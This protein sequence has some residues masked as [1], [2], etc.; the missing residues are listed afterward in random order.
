MT[1]YNLKHQAKSKYAYAYDKHTIHLRLEA[2][3]GLVKNVEVVYGDPFFWGPKPD[4]PD[5][6]EWKIETSKTRLMTKEYSTE[7]NDHFF[8]SVKPK[9]KRMKYAFIINDELLFGC[10]EQVNIK[11]YPKEKKNLF[12]YFNFPYLNEEDVFNPP[13]WIEDQIWYS[14][15]PER[16]SNGDSSINPKETLPWAETNMYSNSQR[17]GGDLQGIIDNL[18]YLEEIGFTGIYMTPIFMSDTAHKYDIINYKKV[19]PAFGSNKKLRELIDK[20][21]K[22]GF[23]I[24][25]DAVFNHCGF[26]HPFFQDVIKNGKDSDYY[27]CFYIIDDDK[28]VVNFDLSKDNRIKRESVKKFHK[29]PDLLNYRSFAFTPYMPKLNTTNPIMKEHLF[30]VARYWI[31]DYNIDGWRLDVSNEVSHSFWRDFRKVVKNANKDAYIVGENWDNSMP[32]LQGEQYD[33]VMNYEFLYPIWNFFGINIDGE[34][35]RPSKFKYTINKVLTDY[36]KNVLRSMYNLVDSH[37]TTR[38]MTICNESSDLVKLPYLFM[39]TLPGAPSVYYGGEIGLPGE[40]DPDNR[41][42]MIWDEDKQDK[43]ILAHIKQLIS[44]RKNYPQLRSANLNW[45]QTNDKQN[46]IIYKKE[47]LFILI[48]NS[49]HIIEINLPTTLQNKV[50][51]DLYNNKKIDL[52]TTITLSN[53]EFKLLK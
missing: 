29:N 39:F 2:T 46:S 25:L 22:K 41:R 35:Y 1:N 15:F 19:D 30:D 20:A 13:S 23:K 24:M 12:N 14:I 42:C 43:T 5:K 53:Y 4:N 10:R 7:F 31:N 37:D 38:I 9:Y 26:R 18:D 33:A 50:V 34:K 40:H 17:F 48:N 8:I 49:N 11:D 51:K 6:W 47:D 21:H 36:P 45:I 52:K 32:W 27:D 3:K 16:F 28:P 44:L